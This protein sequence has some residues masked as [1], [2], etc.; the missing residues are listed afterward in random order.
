MKRLSA[1]L[2]LALVLAVFPAAACPYAK[3]MPVHPVASADIS[4]PFA[5]K[6]RALDLR[7]TWAEGVEKQPV[8]V[9]SHG[10]FGSREGYAPLAVFWAERGYVVIQPTHQDSAKKGTVPLLSNPVAFREWNMRP[11]EISWVISHLGD[12]AKEMPGLAA[13]MDTARIGIAGHSYGAHTVQLL[14]GATAKAPW[15][16]RQNFQ[17]KRA[18]AFVMISPQGGG[19]VFDAESFRTLKGP[20]LFITGTKDETGRKP[21][22]YTWRLDPFEQSPAGDKTLMLID[23]AYHNFGGISGAKYPGAGPEDPATV[24]LVRCMTLA[25]FDAALKK[26]K[27]AADWIDAAT[28]TGHGVPGGAKITQR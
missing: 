23:G 8:I 17:E 25:F 19:G 27:K 22:P 28:S 5:P 1:V 20:A 11:L 9:F 18:Q 16:R 13:A 21:H 12:I 15:S 10:A 26:D 6:K 3:D 2:C 14:A 4:I 24:D 7:V